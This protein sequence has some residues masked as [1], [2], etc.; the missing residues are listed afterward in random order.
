[1]TLNGPIGDVGPAMRDHVA[2]DGETLIAELARVRPL[3]CMHAFVSVEGGLLCEAFEA[4]FAL[5]GTLTG[6]YSH[7]NLNTQ[8]Y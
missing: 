4:Q 3:A 1:M 5:E 6:V 2:L 7:V 8:E